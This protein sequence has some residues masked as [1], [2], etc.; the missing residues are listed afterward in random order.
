MKRIEI[1]LILILVNFSVVCQNH[2]LS[3]KKSIV[4]NAYNFWVYTPEGY[5]TLQEKTPLII[6]LHGA[7]LCGN[8]LDKVRRYGPLHALD[9]GKRIP[10]LIVAPQNNKGAWQPT[11]IN[12]IL[13]WTKKNYALDTNRIYAIGMSLGGYGVLEFVGTYPEKIAAAMALCGGCNL[14]NLQPLGELP[15]WIIHGTADRD[16]PMSQSKKI[17]S[18]LQVKNN[19]KRLRYDWF[20]GVNHA[21]LSRLLYLDDTYRWLLSHS[22]TDEDRKV[23]RDIKLRKED[24]K[25]AYYNLSRTAKKPK[26]IN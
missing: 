1:F 18:A 4:K 11:K 13:E 17:V 3:A 9:M 26:I 5:D 20:K 24:M 19:D 16:V 10:A 25:K 8:N 6:F 15:L 7:S 12:E 14:K 22:L 2:S 21:G 23:N